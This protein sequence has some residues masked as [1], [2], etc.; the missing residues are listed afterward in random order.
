MPTKRATTSGAHARPPKQ[1]VYCGFGVAAVLER[2]HLDMNNANNAH[3]NLA[4]LCPTCH[5][6]HDI[7]LIPTDFIKQRRDDPPKTDWSKLYKDAPIKAKRTLALRRRAQRAVETRRR[8][9]AARKG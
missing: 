9:A 3:D 2:A 4:T 5:R 6:M 8:N 7:G 1:C